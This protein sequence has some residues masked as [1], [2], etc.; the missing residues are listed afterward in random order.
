MNIDLN[1]L[2]IVD[3][4]VISISFTF[5]LALLIIGIY[6]FDFEIDVG[7]FIIHLFVLFIVLIFNTKYV[8]EFK[9]E[10][11]K[12]YYWQSALI[13]FFISAS[14]IFLIDQ[15]ADIELNIYDV[16]SSVFL[17]PVFEE[18]IYRN[19]ILQGLLNN[20]SVLTAVVI[21]SVLFLTSH[22]NIFYQPSIILFLLILSGFSCWVF[23]KTGNIT[24]CIILH[25][26]YNLGIIFIPEVIL[27]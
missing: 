22:I 19:I 13:A 2:S 1:K 6:A 15:K 10:L 18:I 20:Y 21:S 8:K 26:C 3:A 17:G 25:A 24:N 9:K 5:I 23:I 12:K 14:C 16:I 7:S 11:H 27:L 4:F